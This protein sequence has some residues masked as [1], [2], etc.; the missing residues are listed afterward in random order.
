M[1]ENIICKK[2]KKNFPSA[3][4][5]RAVPVRN[6]YSQRDSRS[7]A[8][9]WTPG[10]FQFGSY[11]VINV[12]RPVCAICAYRYA[13]Y[14]KNKVISGHSSSVFIVIDCA[15]RVVNFDLI[16]GDYN[17]NVIQHSYYIIKLHNSNNQEQTAFLG[18]RNKQAFKSAVKSLEL[19]RTHQTHKDV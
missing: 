15:C 12:S 18:R 5:L 7:S 1:D 9:T 3:A 16:C 19:V 8:H 11:T 2:K 10:T 17:E 13:Q 14:V 6:V 4:I